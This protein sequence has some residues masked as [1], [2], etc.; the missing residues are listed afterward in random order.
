MLVDFPN[1]LNLAEINFLLLFLPFQ[2]RLSFILCEKNRF[3][4]FFNRKKA[5][6]FFNNFFF[7]ILNFLFPESFDLLILKRILLE[8]CL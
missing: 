1:F 4:F 8:D 3:F 2:N 7:R 6:D 5:F